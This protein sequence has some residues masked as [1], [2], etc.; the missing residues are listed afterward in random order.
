MNN[1]EN[2]SSRR[3]TTTEKISF[4]L[5]TASAGWNKKKN[6]NL[7]SILHFMEERSLGVAC[8]ETSPQ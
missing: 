4:I 5:L 7:A 1:N 3:R 2:I 6:Y 8:L